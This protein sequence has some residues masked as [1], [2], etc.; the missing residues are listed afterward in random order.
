MFFLWPQGMVPLC[1]EFSILQKE[2]RVSLTKLVS[3]TGKGLIP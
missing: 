3:A 2:L 1:A